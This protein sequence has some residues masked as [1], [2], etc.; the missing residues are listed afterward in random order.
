MNTKSITI[1]RILC[2]ALLIFA[3]YPENPYG[4][5]IFLRCV[6]CSSFTY[7]SIKTFSQIKNGWTW[8]FGITA[9]TYNPII[10][11]HFGRE[12]WSALNIVTIALIIISFF[13]KKGKIA[14]QSMELTVKTP[15]E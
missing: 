7:I 13:I 2:I 4:Y 10:Q 9:G 15:V 11:M 8:I 1:L 5:Y 3:L 12:I 14:N 6:V